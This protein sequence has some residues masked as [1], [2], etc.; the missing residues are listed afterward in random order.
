MSYR[1]LKIDEQEYQ[2]TVGKTHTKIRGL[3]AFKNEDIGDRVGATDQYTVTPSNVTRAIKWHLHIR[4][5]R[6]A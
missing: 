6:N 5:I 3:E 2:Y 4:K 1:K